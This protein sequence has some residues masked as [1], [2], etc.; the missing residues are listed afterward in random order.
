MLRMTDPLGHSEEYHYDA[1][2]RLCRM[3]DRNGI[4][5]TYTY[6]LP[7]ARWAVKVGHFPGQRPRRPNVRTLGMRYSYD[8]N[9]NRTERQ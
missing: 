6:N 3:T 4:E 5:T 7:C 1:G 8:H 2:G 9:G